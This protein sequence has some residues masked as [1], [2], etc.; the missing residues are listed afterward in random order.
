M[1]HTANFATHKNP[2]VV[3][4]LVAAQFNATCKTLQTNTKYNNLQ[5]YHSY[6]KLQQKY[7]ITV[8]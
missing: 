6:C 8:S 2:I 7:D 3:A 5:Q 1:Q 4:L